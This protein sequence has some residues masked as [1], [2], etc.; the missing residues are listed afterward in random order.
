MEDIMYKDLSYAIN[1]ILFEVQN[2]LGTKFQE[3]HY[4]RAVCALL[5]KRKIPYLLEVPITI[6]LKENY[7]AHSERTC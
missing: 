1:G 2:K 7:L 3:K 4:I 6:I 5:D